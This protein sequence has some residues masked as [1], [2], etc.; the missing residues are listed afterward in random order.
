MKNALFLTALA[1]APLPALACGGLFCNTAQPVTQA[2]ERI[3][4][5]RDGEHVQMHVRLTWAGP[6][7]E[8][9]WLLPV[10]PDVET[11]LSSESLFSLLDQAY[12]PVFNLVTEFVGCDFGIDGGGGGAGGAGGGGGF[13]A[14]AGVGGGGVNVLSREQVGPYDRTILQGESVQALLGWLADNEYQVPEG[15]DATLAPYVELGAAFVAIKLLPGAGSNEV[16]P[17][18]LTFTAS[19]PAIPLRPTA[20]AAT[21]DMGIIVHVLGEARAIPVNFRH[22]QINEAAIDWPNF[23]ANYSDVVSQAA[24]EANGKAF[25][26]DYAGAANN[27]LPPVIDLERLGA[28][29]TWDT[30]RSFLNPGDPDL[31]RVLQ[32]TISDPGDAGSPAE[33][34]SCPYCYEDVTLDGAALMERLRTEINPPREALARLFAQHRYMTRLYTTMSASEMEADPIFDE[35]PDLDDVASFHT[36]TQFVPCDENNDVRF[37]RAVIETASG[38]RFALVDGAN[39]EAIQRQ[40]GAT[41]RGQDVPAAAVIEQMLTAGQP[42]LVEDRRPLLSRRYRAA[43]PEDDSCGGCS[44]TG[45]GGAGL[46]LVL[47]AAF[48][49]RRRRAVR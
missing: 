46:A 14:D 19:G 6:P 34:V 17:L 42:Q 32:A 31:Q 5:A 4:F 24:D 47:L 41:V 23:G 38:L 39:P 18:A 40:D 45:T 10:P 7:Q 12:G 22:V 8:F 28:N 11:T 3:L 9:G 16:V 21:P 25:V 36:A 15:A 13:F 27:G 48:R 30:A 43:M 1:A 26:T 2:A 29:P 20:N 33:A 37:D 49:P 35:N 44:A